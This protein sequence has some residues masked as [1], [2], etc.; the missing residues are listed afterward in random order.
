MCPVKTLTRLF[1]A[2]LP[3]N[4]DTECQIESAKGKGENHYNR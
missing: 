2:K 1:E 4:M 3:G